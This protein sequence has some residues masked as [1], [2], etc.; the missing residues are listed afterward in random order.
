MSRVSARWA[1]LQS[2]DHFRRM[3]NDQTDFLAA[4]GGVKNG[5][6]KQRLPLAIGAVGV[7]YGDIG[8]SPLYT[9]RLCFGGTLELAP[10]PDNVMG[11]LSLIFWSVTAV[12]SFKYASIIMRA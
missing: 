10:T 12:V 9:L 4:N 6:V 11:I 7:V 5:H 3:P 2:H 1:R 8:T